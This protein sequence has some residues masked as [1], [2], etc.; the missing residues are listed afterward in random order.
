LGLVLVYGVTLIVLTNI[1][2]TLSQ[3]IDPRIRED[4]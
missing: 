2:E 3:W 1:F 4:V